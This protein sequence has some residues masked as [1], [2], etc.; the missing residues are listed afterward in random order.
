MPSGDPCSALPSVSRAAARAG[1]ASREALWGCVASKA[2]HLAAAAGLYVLAET[3]L[4]SYSPPSGDASIE[5]TAVFPS[6]AAPRDVSIAIQQPQSDGASDP[7]A[8]LSTS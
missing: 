4:L 6:T 1:G 5:L 3:G 8:N 2:V 7:L